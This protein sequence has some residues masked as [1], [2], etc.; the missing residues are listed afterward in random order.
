MTRMF[1]SAVFVLLLVS[2]WGGTAAVAQNA[3]EFSLALSPAIVTLPQGAVTSVTLTFDSTEK[4]SYSVILAGLP[5][6]VQAQTAPVRAG[7]GTVVL[8]ASPDAAVGSFAVQVTARAGKSSQT[9]I[10]TLNVRPMQ[11]VPQWEY[12]VT[13]ANTDAEFIAYANSLGEQGWELVSV[14]FQELTTPSFVGFF[15][16]IKR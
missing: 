14:R 6:G 16:R 8:Y 10:L 9:Q 3:P 4:P 11:P 1:A 2:A 7:M 12:T 15:K 5:D 13:A